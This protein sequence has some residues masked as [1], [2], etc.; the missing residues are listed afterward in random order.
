MT[1]GSVDGRTKC[2]TSRWRT[3][4]VCGCLAASA[5]AN[6]S[7]MSLERG[8]APSWVGSSD[9]TNRPSYEAYVARRGGILPNIV[10]SGLEIPRLDVHSTAAI[11]PFA[12]KY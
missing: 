5:V 9:G 12:R 3:L 4:I 10:R 6:A 11:P 1:Y 8:S 7:A 2:T